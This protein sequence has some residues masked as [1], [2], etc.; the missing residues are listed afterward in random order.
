M[1]QLAGHD[2]LSRR[3][4]HVGVG[5]LKMLGRVWQQ[6]FDNFHSFDLAQKV[7]MPKIA[8]KLAVG[9]SLHTDIFLHLDGIA[10]ASVLDIPQL[11][12][13][14]LAFLTFLSRLTQFRGPEQTT[15][16]IG[17]K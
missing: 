3:A 2:E 15:H 12:R 16:V 10:D 1:P 11:R 13:G 7:G 9:Y 17:A 14:D 5:I 4:L 8:A 6:P